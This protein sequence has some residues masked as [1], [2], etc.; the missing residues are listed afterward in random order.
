MKFAQLIRAG[1]NYL[2]EPTPTRFVVLRALNSVFN[3]LSYE[4]KL[5]CGR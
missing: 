1:L 4:T 3:F 2:S 5:R